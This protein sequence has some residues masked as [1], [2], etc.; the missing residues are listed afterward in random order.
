MTSLS[1]Y[2]TSL[3]VVYTH[4]TLKIRRFSNRV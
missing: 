1:N 4:R 2:A 3:A